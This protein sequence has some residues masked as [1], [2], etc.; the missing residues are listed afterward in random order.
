MVK[1]NYSNGD[2]VSAQS[3]HSQLLAPFRFVGQCVQWSVVARF[4]F[5]FAMEVVGHNVYEVCISLGSD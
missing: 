5:P 1:C 4:R 3:Y 2:W